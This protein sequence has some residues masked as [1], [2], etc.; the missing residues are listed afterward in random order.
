MK[1]KLEADSDS[2]EK[3][4]DI[5]ELGI[6][7]TSSEALG[8]EKR[9]SEDV[10]IS[11]YWCGT[12][13]TIRERTTQISLFYNM[14]AAVDISTDPSNASHGHFKMAF[15]G[16]GRTHGVR[17]VIWACGLEE[18]CDLVISRTKRFF[19]NGASSV[20][21]NLLGL[22][23]GACGVLRLCR[24]LEGFSLF[25][26]SKLSVSCCV[27]DPVPGNLV[28][29][30]TLNCLTLASTA[31]RV[32]RCRVL[33]RVLAIYPCEPL[34]DCAFHAPLIAEYPQGTDCVVEEDV[35]LGCHQGALFSPDYDLACFLSYCRIRRFLS[36]CGT[37]F[38]WNR[39]RSWGINRSFQEEER[40][41]LSR[42]ETWMHTNAYASH[43][44][45][46]SRRQCHSADGCGRC[47]VTRRAIARAV[48]DIGDAEDQRE[49]A[50]THLYMNIYHAQLSRRYRR[51]GDDND[52]RHFR[53]PN[54]SSLL[55]RIERSHAFVLPEPCCV[56]LLL[57]C[58][59]SVALACLLAAGV[60]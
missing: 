54:P 11:V 45:I 33:R 31:L 8:S 34:P 42:I 12:A 52:T 1:N 32:D 17:G 27:F 15:D 18:Q 20:K 29:F 14:T 58:G 40:D 44:T 55:L 57:V 22:S 50:S 5:V 46:I 2:D 35:T 56:S 53:S 13:G 48:D 49:D 26:P 9:R 24:R 59:I 25:S 3:E 23:R 38:D 41:A 10:M 37:R 16:V 60:V 43:T 21:L 7:G 28:L 6:A 39:R 51:S 47:L 4:E 19:K 36:K 30:G